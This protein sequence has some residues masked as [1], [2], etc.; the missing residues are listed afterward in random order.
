MAKALN[1]ESPDQEFTNTLV[2]RTKVFS[3]VTPSQKVAI[4]EMLMS[5]GKTV[6]YVGDGTNDAPALK[7]A[8]IGIAMASNGTD[9]AKAAS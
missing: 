6:A 5:S 8:E 4:V 2:E 1:S 3:R 9:V 7:Y